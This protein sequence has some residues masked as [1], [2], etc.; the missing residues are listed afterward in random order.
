[1][2]LGVPITQS[3]VTRRRVSIGELPDGSPIGI[4]VVTIGGAK[5]GPTLYLQAGIHGDEQTGIAICRGAIGAMDPSEMAGTVVAVPVANVPSY[6]T[7]TRGFLHEERWLIDINRIFPGNP[8][9]LLT[10]RIA[11]ALLNEFARHADLTIDLHSALDGC[12][13]APFVYID[14]DDDEGGTLEARER[15]GLAYGTPYAYYKNRTARL[16]TSDLSRSFSAQAEDAGILT[17]SAEVGE[18]R[19]VSWER[20]ADGVRGIRNVMLAM[21]MLE[22][23]AEER[24]PPRRFSK[25]SLVHAEHGGGL[26]LD[27]DIGDDVTAGQEIGEIVDVFGDRVE[28]IEAST[29]GF[30]LRAMRFGSVTTGAEIVWI[31]S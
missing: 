14:P 18:S 22:G 21:G 12:D 23:E 26:H 2:F 7:R 17:I 25:I 11:D 9:G 19:R 20:V 16:G 15:Y 1:M 13:I 28:R 3:E 4:P 31:A 29:D 27:V 30:I 5:P 6:L 10:E 24:V 8:R